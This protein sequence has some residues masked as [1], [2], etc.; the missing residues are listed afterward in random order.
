MNQHMTLTLQ[1]LL[2]IQKKAVDTENELTAKIE[3]LDK[4]L[5]STKSELA[6]TKEELKKTKAKLGKAE[7][8][9]N[10]TKTELSNVKMSLGETRLMAN[11]SK[12]GLVSTNQKVNL[13]K[14]ASNSAAGEIL[15]L[16]TQAQET[17]TNLEAVK[18]V[19]V[20][21]IKDTKESFEKKLYADRAA[22][23]KTTQKW[24]NENMAA[25]KTETSDKNK[26]LENRM[27]VV[28]DKLNRS[29]M[30]NVEKRGEIYKTID[31]KISQ[32][33]CYLHFTFALASLAV[34]L[35]SFFL[36]KVYSN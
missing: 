31:S 11:A 34:M 29:E 19:M 5:T 22:H 4:N 15:R 28:E 13:N 3:K 20:S 27:K 30:T 24:L 21:T 16:E 17:I 9:L 26:M 35:V 33:K 2:K 23:E 7:T 1:N 32:M 36:Y 8:D 6:A 14:E 25:H 12:A 18:T 10:S